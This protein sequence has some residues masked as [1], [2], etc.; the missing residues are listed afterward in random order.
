VDPR[1]IVQLEGLGKFKKLL[2]GILSRDLLACSIVPQPTTLLRAP[3]NSYKHLKFNLYLTENALHLHYKHQLFNA[4][5]GN[6]NCLFRESYG[7]HKYIVGT[8]YQ[9]LNDK[10][11]SDTAITVFYSFSVVSCMFTPG[12]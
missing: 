2:I 9:V 11:S 3:R 1:A 5:Q 10:P 12:I 6:N 8:Q 4:V 7:G